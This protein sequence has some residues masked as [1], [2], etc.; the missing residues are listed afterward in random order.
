MRTGSDAY[1]IDPAGIVFGYVSF[2][3]ASLRTRCDKSE[4]DEEE[5]E[6]DHA[7]GLNEAMR[8]RKV[9]KGP[10]LSNEPDTG[11]RRG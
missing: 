7:R 3:A 2:I 5:H 1:L 11:Y 8:S 9:E 6:R 4:L 10:D